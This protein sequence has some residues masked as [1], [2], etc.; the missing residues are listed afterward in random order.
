MGIFTDK[1]LKRLFIILIAVLF[2]TV[3]F[4][5]AAAYALA[6]D[7]K[8]QLIAHDY[9]LAGYLAD[10][11][12]ENL[13]L[14]AAFTAVKTDGDYRIGK[15]LLQKVGY[16]QSTSGLFLPEVESVRQKYSLIFL[17]MS[18]VLALLLAVVV[19]SYAYR[20]ERKLQAAAEAVAAFR[21][22]DI[23]RRLEDHEEG[24]L[25]RLFAS[26]NA[27]T[28][29]LTSHLAQEKQNKEFLK[30]TISD[31][32]HQLKTPLAALRMYNEII[33]D[34]N[35]GNTVVAD[36]TAKS[37]NEL[38]RME[39]LIQNLL[40]LARLDAGVIELEKRKHSVKAFLAES[41]RRFSTRA[42]LED[43][44]IVL[45]GD[46]SLVLNFDQEWLGEAVGNI[47]K[48][49]LDHTKAQD[50]IEISCEE[51]PVVVRI[52][53]KDSGQG[54][55]PEDIHHIFKRFYRSRFSQDRQGVGIG[56]A[57]AKTIVE[58]H[59]GS[60]L[61]ESELGRGTTFSFIFPKLT[62]V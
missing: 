32:S 4:G 38:K 40:K 49:A 50:K 36:F 20:Q 11:G 13:K 55:H 7:Y 16:H 8:Q 53:I 41:L 51:T 22:G 27:L 57:L 26:V 34:E 60:V 17:F 58:K 6:A 5:Q 12:A 24:S 42:E 54:I 45:K 15:E 31:I 47:L 23:T 3:L 18:L 62:N 2:S 29:T 28:T 37:E 61:A 33:Q 35:T 48:N 19:Y 43:K 21:N 59:G 1:D 25:A 9:A 39:D 10:N 46:D 52:M 14:P 44:S 56:L 30:D